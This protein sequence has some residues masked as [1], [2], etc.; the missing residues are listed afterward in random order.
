M[1]T[2]KK[3]KIEQELI[4][5]KLQNRISVWEKHRIQK[6]QQQLDNIND[7]TDED[8]KEYIDIT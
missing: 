2:S 4:A 1:K 6:L 7:N 3:T 8:S 5:L